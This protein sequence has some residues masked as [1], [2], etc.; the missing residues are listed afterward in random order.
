MSSTSPSEADA[1]LAR[2]DQIV[3]AAMAELPPGAAVDVERLV[4]AHPELERELR[5]AALGLSSLQ[6][7]SER[8]TGPP[9]PERIGPYRVRREVGRGGM[10]VVYEAEDASLDRLVALK[11]L[12]R[13]ISMQP[14]YVERFQREA[15]AAARLEHPNVV[16][17][18][19]VDEADGQHYIV[20]K[21][22]DG[23]ALDELADDLRVTTGSGSNGDGSTEP[24][25]SSRGSSDLAGLLVSGRIGPTDNDLE[26]GSSD[27]ADEQGGESV[28]AGRA[29]HRNVARIARSVARALEY[30]HE[31][32]VLHRD[33]KPGNV[34]VDRTGQVW[35]TDFGLAKI[36]E[37][38]DLTGAGGFVGTLRY[39]AP[40]QFHGRAEPRSDVYGL[41]L[42]LY[43][44]L[45]LQRAIGGE[46]RAEIVH[47]V[48]YGTP[49]NPRSL[50]AGVPEDLAH[51][52]MKAIAKLPEQRYPDA[53]S[54]GE[55]LTA[56]LEGKPVAARIPSALYVTR[57]ALHRNRALVTAL[58]FAFFLV[59]V[60]AIVYVAQLRRS[61]DSESLLAYRG[62]IAAAAAEVQVGEIPMAEAHLER[63]PPAQRGW[64]WRHLNAS[65]DQSLRTVRK[66]G[67][68]VRRM[69]FHEGA[70]QLV[71]VRGVETLREDGID[72]V[73]FPSSRSDRGDTMF[74]A[75]SG[76]AW[77]AL[78]YYKGV[79]VCPPGGVPVGTPIPENPD[80]AEG[81]ET[82]G[83]IRFA[84]DGGVSADGR[85]I[86]LVET[87]GDIVV[88]DA[89]TLAVERRRRTQIRGVLGLAVHPDG[90]LGWTVSDEGICTE[91]DLETL[92]PTVLPIPRAGGRSVAYHAGTDRLA[93]GRVDHQI[94]LYDRGTKDVR[95]LVGH[96]APV[97]A[98]GFSND[99]R[100]LSSADLGDSLRTWDLEGNQASRSLTG[101]S[102]RCRAILW[103]PSGRSF[104]TAGTSGDVQEWG[105][106]FGG[107]HVVADAHE[108][109]VA[110]AAFSRDGT[111]V[112]TGGRDATIQ[113]R[114][115]ATLGLERVMLGHRFELSGVAFHAQDR[116][117]IGCDYGGEM[118]SFDVDTGRERWRATIGGVLTEP[119][120]YRVA[121]RER[122]AV[123]SRAGR[124]EIRDADSGDV[125]AEAEMEG[126]SLTSLA[127][128]DELFVAGT[129]TGELVFL[130][131]T[132][133]APKRRVQVHDR[134]VLGITR[135]A[136][137][138]E[139]V[140]SGLDG[141]VAFVGVDDGRVRAR[142][143]TGGTGRSIDTDGLEAVAV[144]PDG[145]RIAVAS[146]GSVVRL[147]DAAD[148][149]RLLDLV[150]HERWVRS[151][152]FSP[153]GSK[154]L[155]TDSTASVMVWD[156]VDG[157][158]RA[159]AVAERSELEEAAR[160]QWAAWLGRP[161][162]DP[163]DVEEALAL[164]GERT[165]HSRPFENALRSVL[166][167]A[168]LNDLP[169]TLERR[170][171]AAESRADTYGALQFVKGATRR[172]PDS[173]EVV[174]VDAVTRW[175]QGDA[176]TCRLRL[177]RLGVLDAERRATDVVVAALRERLGGGPAAAEG[178]VSSP[179][180]RGGADPV[181]AETARRILARAPL[182]APEPASDSD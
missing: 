6:R 148:G 132:T 158:T 15:L 75:R 46:E 175:V 173:Y 137:M 39:T 131:G 102:G 142:T 36:G 135:G 9:V 47:E 79:L 37:E 10:G 144:S 157:L 22:V 87:D 74:A 8:L 55:D 89:E 160:A 17:V 80:D 118:L 111:R 85:R 130:D 123:A 141:F 176:D 42:V 86:V 70:L 147:L 149:E 172:R 72:S 182:P 73:Q 20:M 159:Q 3:T 155:S 27:G 136:R 177:E 140:S 58:L 112:V 127:L 128:F 62:Q 16:P 30:A 167:Q 165:I 120:V 95:L 115:A 129:A 134:A 61:A 162:T 94:A 98:V 64:E 76:D 119:V 171:L 166:F 50:R 106:G 151:V 59:G 33:V 41:G 5:A 32:G 12:P 90:M 34:L 143:Q 21:L 40:E 91:W 18:Y 103:H 181:D 96:T 67:E 43:E 153:D 156:A 164:L 161:I 179:D 124:V 113:V 117:V 170:A 53:R 51:I 83:I 100:R 125:L 104:F 2:V 116:R 122:V 168:R 97:V 121:E 45:A 105:P 56:F 174:R 48:L 152:H 44:L 4:A 78:S 26:S 23:V 101:L 169:R 63:C 108:S 60:M 82:L 28:R 109:D 14:G 139:V 68:T 19:G 52:A 99:G 65:S 25:P 29:Y 54:M 77:L 163:D 92:E 24:P 11:V 57:L 13:A 35:V 1:R 93:V 84:S 38:D 150:G 146:R 138:R 71:H 107:G 145:A 31:R 180:A 66:V 133:L 81:F 126:T 110:G 154:L 88:I 178:D 7:S 49:P 69:S 114:S